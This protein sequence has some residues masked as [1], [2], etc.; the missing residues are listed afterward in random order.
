MFKDPH[1]SA[2]SSLQMS[3]DGDI[4]MGLY[5]D[6][7]LSGE[8]DGSAD[9]FEKIKKEG[10]LK[11]SMKNNPLDEMKMAMLGFEPGFISTDSSNLI[12]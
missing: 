10:R 1:P 7:E 4:G 6:S 11:L 3:D 5:T 12:D 8:S 9:I 2:V